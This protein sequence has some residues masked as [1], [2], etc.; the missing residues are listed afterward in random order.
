M[1]SEARNRYRSSSAAR[2]RYQR[3]RSN[4]SEQY[5]QVIDEYVDDEDRQDLLPP[6]PE[7]WQNNAVKYVIKKFGWWILVVMFPYIFAPIIALRNLYSRSKRGYLAAR[8]AHDKGYTSYLWTSL[9]IGFTQFVITA[10]WV[11]TMGKYDLTSFFEKGVNSSPQRRYNLRRRRDRDT[12]SDTISQDSFQDQYTSQ[13]Q[14]LEDDN[15]SRRREPTGVFAPVKRA[16]SFVKMCGDLLLLG[17]YFVFGWTFGRFTEDE[18]QLK[19]KRQAKKDQ[20]SRAGSFGSKSVTSGE[21]PRETRQ[22]SSSRWPWIIV[23]IILLI[24]F[25]NIFLKHYDGKKHSPSY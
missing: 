7:P 11:C 17:F 2:N 20:L 25:W 16:W 14:L 23:A 15:N 5:N 22:E 6:P 13:D 3:L 4:E 1:S 10:V 19:T 9:P 18:G 24:L 12:D 8:Y 21:Q